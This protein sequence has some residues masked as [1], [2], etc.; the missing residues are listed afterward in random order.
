MSR[1]IR[2]LLNATQLVE[3]RDVIKARLKQHYMRLKARSGAPAAI[4][5]EGSN[6]TSELEL[7]DEHAHPEIARDVRRKI[8]RRATYVSKRHQRLNG[9]GHLRPEQRC[10]LLDA[11]RIMQLAEIRSI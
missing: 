5:A 9:L 2:F 10:K 3:D 1:K 6:E 7:L 11:P 4:E 8:E